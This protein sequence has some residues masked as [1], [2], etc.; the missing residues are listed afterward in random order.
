MLDIEVSRALFSLSKKHPGLNHVNFKRAVDGGSLTVLIVGPGQIPLIIGRGGRVAQELERCL[1]TKIR[2]VEDGSTIRK[3]AQDILAP[4][5]VLG[6][7]VLYTKIGK[8][9]HVRVPH[10]HLKRLPC[11]IHDLESL[12]GKLSDNKAVIVLE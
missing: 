12:I 3:L 5:E 6:V 8:E 7:N 1:N 10:S 2:G 9:Y 11:K 4:A